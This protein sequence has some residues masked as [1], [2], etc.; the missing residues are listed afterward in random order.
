MRNGPVEQRADKDQDADGTHD[1]RQ[2]VQSAISRVL[3]IHEAKEAGRRNRANILRRSLQPGRC[4][5]LL[6]RGLGDRPRPEMPWRTCLVERRK[7]SRQLQSAKT[8]V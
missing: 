8:G 3:A 5:D 6:R 4:T 1:E 7:R 2:P